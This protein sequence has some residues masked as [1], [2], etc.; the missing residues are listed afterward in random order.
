MVLLSQYFD[1]AQHEF[2]ADGFGKLTASF[3]DF[4]NNVRKTVNPIRA[5]PWNWDNKTIKCYFSNPCFVYL[6]SYTRFLFLSNSI[7]CGFFFPEVKYAVRGCTF[8]KA[9]WMLSF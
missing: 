5:N 6:N 9:G 1:P 4:F 8:D 3:T 7:F 2:H